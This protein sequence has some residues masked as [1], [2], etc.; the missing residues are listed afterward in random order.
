M[1]ISIDTNVRSLRYYIHVVIVN[2]FIKFLVIVR[3]IYGV[4]SNNAHNK[5]VPLSV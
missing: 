4:P 1:E 5:T 2:A 3:S